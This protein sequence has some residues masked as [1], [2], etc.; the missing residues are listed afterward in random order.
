MYFVAIERKKNY[1]KKQNKKNYSIFP[2][3]TGNLQRNIGKELNIHVS[4]KSYKN[5]ILNNVVDINSNVL[6]FDH[7]S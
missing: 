3:I 2:I 7:F 4:R 1:K 6:N 5:L